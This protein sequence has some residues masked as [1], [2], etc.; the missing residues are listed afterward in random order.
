MKPKNSKVLSGNK[1]PRLSTKEEALLLFA[2]RT[3]VILETHEEWSSD[4]PDE[5]AQAAFAG[6][7]AHTDASGMFR[8]GAKR[9]GGQ[10]K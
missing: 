3:L 7:V 9:W 4:I 10:S 5:I 8:T 6:D 1:P 2:K